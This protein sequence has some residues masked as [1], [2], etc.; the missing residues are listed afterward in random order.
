MLFHGGLE[1]E[2]GHGAGRVALEG[3]AVHGGLFLSKR[4]RNHVHGEFHEALYAQVFLGGHAEHRDGLSLLQAQAQ[5][6][7]DL[8]RGE[9]HGL[10]ELLHEFVGTLGS[11]FHEFSAEFL[12]FVGIGGGDVQFL[13]L[14]IVIFHGDDVHEAFQTGTGVHRELAQGGLFAELLVDGIAN[15]FP[16]GFVVVQ[17]VHG[18]D[19][20]NAVLVCV[21]GIQGGT[22]LDAGR[23]VHDH[24]SRI[25]HLKGSQGA[26]GEIVRAGSVDEVDLAAIK[27]CVQRSG[28][29]GLLVGL[30]ELGVVR[31]G[32]FVFHGA[33][34]VD[35]LSFKQHSLRQ[36]GFTAAGSADKD[37]VADVFSCVSFHWCY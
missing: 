23:A 10:E 35:D 12:G 20:R 26:T 9:F 31:H 36:G 3:A 34:T 33:A 4:R 27:L 25:H 13:V 29:D 21:A 37:N 2:Q 5:T 8:V 32:V 22:Y 7:A 11:L 14:L 28:V 1:D 24:D 19:H 15:A 6:F 16:V 30:L 17:L 18:N